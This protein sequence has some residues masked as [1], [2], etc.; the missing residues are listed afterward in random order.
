MYTFHLYTKIQIFTTG[1]E[2]G[3]KNGENGEILRQILL[4][5]VQLNIDA[6]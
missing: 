1:G 5:V 3:S 2:G 6:T 4:A